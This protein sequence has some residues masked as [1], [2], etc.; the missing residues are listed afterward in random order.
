MFPFKTAL[1]AY[2][3]AVDC[4]VGLH[5]FLYPRVV[6]LVSI[7]LIADD[8]VAAG[9]K[10]NTWYIA[11][12]GGSIAGLGSSQT[13]FTYIPAINTTQKSFFYSKIVT[14]RSIETPTMLNASTAA[15]LI[16]HRLLQPN[17]RVR[18]LYSVDTVASRCVLS[19][20]NNFADN[21]GKN[22]K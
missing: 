17:P 20:D 22:D 9:G 15:L 21:R 13:M 10:H 1:I 3:V 16:E 6:V 2:S 8:I 12:S 11:P 19:S 7:V 5:G 18:Y 14:K 4:I